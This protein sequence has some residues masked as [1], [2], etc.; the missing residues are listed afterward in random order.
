M[1]GAEALGRVTE[2]SWLLGPGPQTA[3]APAPSA[4]LPRVSKVTLEQLFQQQEQEEA[5][6][7]R[8]KGEA[9]GQPKPPG[10]ALALSFA[11]EAEPDDA[12]DRSGTSVHSY[13]SDALEYDAMMTL[14]APQNPL[15]R[16]RVRSVV[17]W[18]A[19]SAVLFL[20][21]QLTMLPVGFYPSYAQDS[22]GMSPWAVN[23]FFSLY[24]LCIMIC[25][26]LA[27]S[28]TPVIGRQS[29][30]CLGLMLSGA[31]TIAFAYVDSI[32]SVFML[33][34]FQG[35]GAGA[36]GT[37]H[38]LFMDLLVCTNPPL[39]LIVYIVVGA[40]SV[41]TE[42]FEASVG[43]I[44]VVQEFVVAA[45]FVSAPPLGSYLY[46]Y[47]GFEMPFLVL[48]AAQLLAVLIIPYLFIEYSLPDGL[49][50]HGH[51]SRTLQKTTSFREAKGY[52]EVLT[53]VCL[54]CLGITTFAMASFG[55]I[56]PYLG[57]HLQLMLGAQHLIVGFGFAVNALVY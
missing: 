41:Q 49:Y 30:V 34:V 23:L 31:S 40:V 55:F 3:P 54:V 45:A 18:L 13:G 17:I 48:G 50:A 21:N 32:S 38:C 5:A 20:A 35:V 26:P 37:C 24:P 57:S 2:G 46:E 53:P 36:A 14:S 47:Y 52:R 42:E 15:Q 27:A 10:G 6:V 11:A 12:L 51:T 4:A 1:P 19:T 44:V 33:R 9:R 43:H 16:A 25:S 28:A 8:A 7:R 22:L 29:L 39:S 56:D